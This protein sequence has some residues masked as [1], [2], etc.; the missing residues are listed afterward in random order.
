VCLELLHKCGV[1]W[2]L[3]PVLKRGHDLPH[4]ASEQGWSIEPEPREY[5]GLEHPARVRLYFPIRAVLQ[6]KPAHHALAQDDHHIFQYASLLIVM[7]FR[8][9]KNSITLP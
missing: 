1:L 3:D 5:S 4:I 2:C 6:D 9:A 7:T 8:V